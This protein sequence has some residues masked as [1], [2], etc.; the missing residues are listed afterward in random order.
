[1]YNTL[2]SPSV[3][4]VGISCALLVFK[5]KEHNEVIGFWVAIDCK[6]MLKLGGR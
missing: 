3:L 5:S 6:N 2:L 1:M 4:G